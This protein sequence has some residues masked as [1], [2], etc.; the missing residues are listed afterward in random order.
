MPP[1]NVWREAES[2]KDMWRWHSNQGE[3]MG[4]DG[5]DRAERVSESIRN[6]GTRARNEEAF[7]P[8]SILQT[9]GTRD[10]S[11]DAQS[12]KL[13]QMRTPDGVP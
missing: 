11:L 1:K 13:H 12:Q 7:K 5:I 9:R 4:F 2:Q 8:K 10:I 3:W 6:N